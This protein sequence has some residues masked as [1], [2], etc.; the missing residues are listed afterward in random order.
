M[1]GD[2]MNPIRRSFQNLTSLGAKGGKYE[3]L[4][5]DTETP[6]P[7]HRQGGNDNDNDN[8]TV[9]LNSIHSNNIPES[10]N[11]NTPE[12]GTSAINRRQAWGS[13]LG[14]ILA[15]TGSAIGLGN[16]WKFPYITG[17]YGGGAFVSEYMN[18]MNCN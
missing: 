13:R 11:T 9:E 7:K 17:I 4:S 18:E 6:L 14:F 15:S 5:Q 8:G 10:V 1:L 16:I 3:N 2:D 12:A